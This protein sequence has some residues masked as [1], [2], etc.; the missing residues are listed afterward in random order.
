MKVIIYILIIAS[1]LIAPVFA[2]ADC[3][4]PGT[5]VVFIN[6]M[7]TP[8][9]EEADAAKD[10]LK[11]AYN[12][13]GKTSNVSFITGYNESHVIF[14]GDIVSAI[15]QAY[16]GG[17]VD[18]DLTTILRNIHSEINTQKILL[19]GHSQG[20]F[21]TNAAYDYLV[22]HGVDQNSIAVYNV[23]TPA[24]VVAGNG[25]YLTSSTDKLISSVVAKL[26][27][28]FSAR[29]PLAPN[30]T[31]K[32]SAAEQ[33]DPLG[34]HSFDNVYLAEAPDRIVGDMDSELS[35]L[36]A[37][38]ANKSECFTEPP[39]D[40]VYMI[41]DAGY[42]TIDGVIGYM[43]PDIMVT[44]PDSAGLLA[45]GNSL[46]S[47]AYNAG[48]DLIGSIS[49]FFGGLTSGNSSAASSGAS[50]A[51]SYAGAGSAA[52]SPV[53]SQDSLD[54]TLEQLDALNPAAL[55][56]GAAS[57]YPKLL[58][59]EIQDAG[60]INAK[61]EFVELY[62]PNNFSVPMD[63]WSLTHRGSTG[64][65]Y[66]TYVSKN[67]MDGTT[68]PAKGY[69][70]IARKNSD[71]ESLANVII[72]AGQPLR[73]DN[74]LV[75]V[76]PD[77]NTVDT[78]GWGNAQDYET[79]PT[80]NPPIDQS[81]VR[82]WDSVNQTSQDTD[83]NYVDFGREVPPTPK[84]QN[85]PVV[86]PYFNL[87]VCYLGANGTQ[88]TKA[89]FG[90][91]ASN[92]YP[93]NVTTNTV[94]NGGIVPQ[95]ITVG[96][97]TIRVWSSNT[98]QMNANNY[99]WT[100]AID[101]TTKTSTIDTLNGHTGSF[102]DSM[103]CPAV[104]G[105]GF[106]TGS[107][108]C[109]TCSA[110]CGSC[111]GGGGGGLSLQVSCSASPNP[112]ITNQQVTFAA[113]A[114]GGLSSSY[115]YS[116][117]GDCV[118][119]PSAPANA[120]CFNTFA[121]AGNYAA[122]V[123]VTPWP[124]GLVVV[125][126]TA[127]CPVVVNNAA[128]PPVITLLGAPEL[129][130]TVGHDY[131][132]QGATATDAIDGDITSK[133][134]TV[135][136]VNKNAIGDYTI[137]YNVSD[138]AGLAA[139]QV[140]RIVHVVSPF[141]ISC[142]TSPNPANY[143]DEVVFSP[144]LAFDTSDCT[145]SWTSDC[146][147]SQTT[148]TNPFKYGGTY[149]AAVNAVCD[150]LFSSP[151]T[152]SVDVS[153]PLP[154]AIVSANNPDD[155]PVAFGT[156]LADLPLPSTV[157]V[158]LSDGN[159]ENMP[160]IWA[161]TDG[162]DGNTAQAYHFTGTFNTPIPDHI[163]NPSNVTAGVYI[164]V[165]PYSGH[166]LITEVQTAGATST[167]DE[168]IELYNPTQSAIDLAG[169][170]LTKKTSSGNES[171]LVSH[172][173][174]TGTINPADYFL[175]VP[176]GNCHGNPTYTGAQTPDL[177]YSGSSSGYSI[178]DDNTILLYDNKHNLID[179]VG[180]GNAADYETAPT[181]NPPVSQSIE[182][183]FDFDNWIYQDTD[184]NLNDFMVEQAPNPR[185]TPPPPPAPLSAYCYASPPDVALNESVSFISQAF[186]GVGQ[187][188]YSWTG[189]CTGTGA[190]C[191]NSFAN[192]GT[193]T[194]KL[195]VTSGA[196]NVNA[197]CQADV[198][199]PL[200]NA[201]VPQD[202]TGCLHL[203]NCPQPNYSSNGGWV[204]INGSAGISY[205][206]PRIQWGST[207][208]ASASYSYNVQYKRNNGNW[209]DWLLATTGTSGIFYG[210]DDNGNR[211][212]AL[213]DMLN[214]EVYS[215]RVRANTSGTEGL[216]S[217]ELKIDLTNPVV[218][219]EVAPFGTGDGSGGQWLELYN[220]S[221]SDVKLDGWTIHGG[222]GGSDTLTINLSGSIPHK[223]YL[224]ID[225]ATYFKN[226]DINTSGYLYLSNSVNRATDSFYIPNDNNPPGWQP[227]QFQKNG[228]YYSMER[229]SPYGFGSNENNWKLSASADYGTPGNQNSDYQLYTPVSTDF[230]ESADLPVSANGVNFSPYLFQGFVTVYQN[231]TLTIDPGAV[232]KFVNSGSSTSPSGLMVWGTLLANGSS[233]SPVVF[234]SLH[235][236]DYA[237]PGCSTGPYPGCD[238]DEDGGPSSAQP[239]Y[240]N[241]IKF[242]SSG[243]GSQMSNVIVR[244]AGDIWNDDFGA[245]IKVDTTSVS[246]SNLTVEKNENDGLYLVNSASV[247]D[248]AKILDN[249]IPAGPITAGIR[250]DG[251]SPTISN[252]DFERNYYGIFTDLAQSSPSI[253]HCTVGQAADKNT[254]DS[255][256]AA[257]LPSP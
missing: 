114:T 45:F 48:A 153:G 214:D 53:S 118:L 36:Q 40:T 231:K 8:T 138:S 43:S 229:V 63:G 130:I 103:R 38:S 182:R 179:K 115:S 222:F 71:F 127:T 37:S 21:Y 75:L 188:S 159:M 246:L 168:F 84:A 42:A 243:S 117:S 158:N 25:K 237:Y 73:D 109:S 99:V 34:G 110:D 132:D 242:S 46:F 68:I 191:Q 111:G 113:T 96:A 30:I 226:S 211:I 23:G 213:D 136:P 14:I 70:L 205:F 169:Y 1:V 82:I 208:P 224:L 172:L 35:G 143:N 31:L 171:D 152:C 185:L 238:T 150:G 134:V 166:L 11:F 66:A 249:N 201:T 223:S 177:C 13:F 81:I 15:T 219:N 198:L 202:V 92:L 61:N 250:I 18:Y 175:I 144:Q 248:S 235:D 157:S 95:G 183:I 232:V 116:W 251:G 240:W 79:K 146:A 151:A 98:Y 225:K 120:N 47:G 192:A 200:P 57:S 29:K 245:G 187:D 129:S 149:T 2:L 128:I 148:C 155:I 20:T 252:S 55:T 160:V 74:T 216:W 51:T 22:A 203:G 141:P 91:L 5:T 126:A 3:N 241:G 44:S 88:A 108:I 69:Y 167:K 236:D 131:A 196:E 217:P 49:D 112:G 165:Q 142:S 83:N 190:N 197:S 180:Y 256:P 204:A 52:Q 17:Y 19:V 145:F 207:D 218:I 140:V 244:Y 189:D 101:G 147:G 32:L 10:K 59:N 39:A 6:G 16:F 174:F 94:T 133:I 162:Y 78:V 193:Y 184:N 239:G 173:K 97:S 24:D 119:T 105:D 137:T 234:T 176:Y 26:T 56:Q 254:Y 206:S 135:N 93:D 64:Q 60:S 154:P 33:A 72:T 80:I 221:D 12:N 87:A 102:Y 139:P 77:G 62:N 209:Q 199:P 227:N 28:L 181:V 255:S 7:F 89:R 41:E 54:N 4:Q 164:L 123:T 161:A 85:T 106:C 215:F 65:G 27:A 230:A 178:A 194:A 210:Q 107:E 156:L 220:K 76:N 121:N 124:P 125:S 90:Y 247:V 163:T 9:K 195:S 122:T 67:A 186:G 170:Y 86:T 228:Q 257:L 212:A 100:V 233:G 58:I 50:T 253:Q 104:C